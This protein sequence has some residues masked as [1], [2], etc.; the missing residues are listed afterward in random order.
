MTLSLRVPRVAGPV[1]HQLYIYMACDC[2]VQ[3]LTP[4]SVMNACTCTVRLCLGSNGS[5]QGKRKGKDEQ[6][7]GEVCPPLNIPHKKAALCQLFFIQIMSI[8]ISIVLP[9]TLSLCCAG[10]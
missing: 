9:F 2:Y 10:E 3:I 1:I 4:F 8:K 7:N 5:K 6:Q